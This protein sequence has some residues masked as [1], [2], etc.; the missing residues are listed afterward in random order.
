MY[1]VNKQEAFIIRLG[2]PNCG[3]LWVLFSAFM[4]TQSSIRAFRDKYC[5]RFKTEI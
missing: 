5:G 1:I 2:G 3:Y 4:D